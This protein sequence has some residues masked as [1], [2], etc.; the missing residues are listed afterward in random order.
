MSLIWTAPTALRQV[1]RTTFASSSRTSLQKH[2]RGLHSSARLLDSPYFTYKIAAAFSGKSNV[3]DGTKHHFAFDS[4]TG[5]GAYIDPTITS[6]GRKLPSGQDSFFISSVGDSSAAAFAV[7][8]GVG[9]YKDHGVD[10]AD[11]A[12]G[13][14]RYMRE[15]AEACSGDQSSNERLDAL[16]LLWQGYSKLCSDRSIKGGGSTACVAIAN[17]DGALNVA[18]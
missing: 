16:Q 3:F 15:T 2:T 12:H 13:L 4:S 17:P 7:A 18:K 9:G 5:V 8:D 6:R 11:F 1:Q 10:S 14:T